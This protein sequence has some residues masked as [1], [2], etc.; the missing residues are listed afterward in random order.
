MSDFRIGAVAVRYGVFVP[1][2]YNWCLELGFSPERMM[3]SCAFCP[4]E[5]QGF[6]IILMAKHFGIFPFN[7]G[8]AGGVVAAGRHFVFASHGDDLVLVQASHVGY[9]PKTHAFGSYRRGRTG[10]FQHTEAC[11]KVC[12]ILD[13][14]LN[15]YRRAQAGLRIGRVGGK[16]AVAA[17]NYLLDHERTEGLFLRFDRLVAERG[18][19]GPIPFRVLSTAKVFAVNDR[20]RQ[21]LPGE[22]FGEALKP[23]GDYLTS[24]LFDFRRAVAGTVQSQDHVEHNLAPVMRAIVTA[25]WPALDAACYNTEIEFDRTCRSIQFEPGYKGKNLLFISGLNIDISPD[26]RVRFPLTKFVPWAAYIRRA[27]GR[28][29]VIEQ[30]DLVTTLR[31]QPSGNPNQIELDGEI[32]VTNSVDDILLPPL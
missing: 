26:G 17:D 9:D 15:E 31:R 19:E 28:S 16:L 18:E 11:G 3:P 1:Q 29:E 14:Y 27:D 30:A 8:R 20:L 4:D 24:D 5:S 12:A 6:P 22:A 13:W 21:K 25:P 2:L 10:N 32:G 7:H 23:I